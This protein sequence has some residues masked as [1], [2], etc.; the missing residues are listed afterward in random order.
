M[1]ATHVLVPHDDG[2]FYVA[3]LLGSTG[4]WRRPI[5]LTVGSRMP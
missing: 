3:E 5:H 4:A 1:P 2:L